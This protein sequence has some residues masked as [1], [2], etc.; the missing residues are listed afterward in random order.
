MNELL[1]KDYA[2]LL[3]DIKERVRTA[4]YAALR[5]VSQEL[6]GLYWDIGRMI[7]ERQGDKQTWVPA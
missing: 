1:P 5:A 4:Q 3:A 6:V 7:V 2:V